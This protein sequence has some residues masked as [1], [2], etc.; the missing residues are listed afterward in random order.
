MLGP[1]SAGTS[2]EFSRD[3]IAFL[4]CSRF[5]V[6]AMFAAVHESHLSLRK[7][8][9]H[10]FH[11]AGFGARI[12]APVKKQRR[13]AKFAQPAIVKIFVSSLN[14]VGDPQP[15]SAVTARHVLPV[16]FSVVLPEQLTRFFAEVF[17]MRRKPFKKTS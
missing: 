8:V 6:R 3:R 11:L 15:S 10:A 2:Q 7:F 1:E 12:K 17:R 13:H 16:T 5:A 4:E 14:L 9:A